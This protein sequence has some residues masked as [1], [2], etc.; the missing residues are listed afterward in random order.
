MN[1]LEKGNMLMKLLRYKTFNGSYFDMD[2]Y[3]IPEF[4]MKDLFNWRFELFSNYFLD[5]TISELS[6]LPFTK[7]YQ[8]FMKVN[9]EYY[10]SKGKHYHEL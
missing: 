1:K 7:Y 5:T 2:K 10:K 8:D 3:Y 9:D 6:K 4:F